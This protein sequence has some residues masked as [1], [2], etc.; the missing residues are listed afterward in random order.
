MPL[1]L[2]PD[3]KLLLHERVNL[4][5][6]VAGGGRVVSTPWS[7]HAIG[8]T[9][10]GL[11]MQDVVPTTSSAHAIARMVAESIQKSQH[12]IHIDSDPTELIRANRHGDEIS[13]QLAEAPNQ[14]FL[15][16]ADGSRL[17][18]GIKPARTLRFVSPTGNK[19]PLHV[20]LCVDANRNGV[21]FRRS[22]TL[23][24]LVGITDARFLASSEAYAGGTFAVRAIYTNSKSR[25]PVAGHKEVI[26]LVQ[27][28]RVLAQTVSPSND[29]GIVNARLWVPHDANA[30]SATLHVGTD[31]RPVTVKRSVR[32]SLVTDR[33]L[34][35][36]TDRVHARVMVHEVPSGRPA[37]GRTVTL[38]CGRIKK[39]VVTSNFGIASASFELINESVGTSKISAAVD[40][41]FATSSFRVTAYETPTFRVNV[42]PET[43]HLDKGQSG[44]VEVTVTTLSGKP[45]AGA[46]VHFEPWW[47]MRTENQNMKTDREGQT[48]TTVRREGR[49]R[50]RG[51]WVHV[52]DAD[53]RTLTREVHVRRATTAAP[54]RVRALSEL[55][56]GQPGT[57]SV[58]AK[59]RR[60]IILTIDFKKRLRVA[61][62]GDGNGLFEATPKS[63]VVFIGGAGFRPRSFPVHVADAERPGP[64]L[65][66]DRRI[67]NVGDLLTG[68]IVGPDGTVLLDVL[69]DDVIIRT[70]A[71]HIKDG[72]AKLS[73][74]LEPDL[75]GHLTIRA[76]STP[77]KRTRGSLVR[78][79]VGRGRTLSVEAKS[80]AESY[81]PGETARLDVNVRDPRGRPAPGVLGYWAIDQAVLDLSSWSDGNESRFDLARD[82]EQKTLLKLKDS[83]D[84]RS[85]V[86]RVLGGIQNLDKY[87][88][89]TY[90][91]GRV[92]TQRIEA[93]KRSVKAARA[94]M[95]ALR[96]RG[97]EAL[98]SVPL[99]RLRA[100][101]SLRETVRWLIRRRALDATA[102]IDPWGTP[103][104]VRNAWK[105]VKIYDE[106][107]GDRPRQWY[108]YT[109]ERAFPCQSAGPDRQ[110]NTMDD[111]HLAWHVYQPWGTCSKALPGSFWRLMADTKRALTEDR[112]TEID[113]GAIERA[114]GTNI[115]SLMNGTIGI[116][117]GSGG[118]F[119]G[120][121]GGR[122]LGTGGGGR[123]KYEEPVKHV[124]S[125]FLPTLCFV[126]EAIV[127]PDGK[128]E[129]KID[130]ADNITTWKTR[131]V[132]ST[133]E[134]ATGVG[135]AD[136]VVE[137][138]LHA[139]PWV[140]PR[141]TDGDELELPVA[142]RN[143]TDQP[144]NV[145]LHI[146]T[147]E[148][149]D[150]EGDSRA[151]VNVPARGTGAHRFR[152]RA[153]GHGK[154]TIKI[155][156]Q[157]KDK[158]DIAKHTVTVRR[159]AR[160]VI[161]SESTLLHAGTSWKPSI[162]LSGTEPVEITLYPSAMADVVGGFEGLIRKPSGCFE[163]T[164]S[165]L[166]PM[167]LALD[168]LRRSGQAHAGLEDR[169]RKHVA[170][171]YQRLLGFE[172]RRSPG[173]FSL[174]GHSP[175][176]TF[177][178]AYGLMEFTDMAR[179][180]EID[181]DLRPRMIK[182]LRGR[183]DK[184]GSWG[185]PA[186][187][188]HQELRSHGKHPRFNSTAYTAWA[189][190]KAGESTD[191]A[192]EWIQD[193]VDEI[194]S[195]YS[196]SL[197]ALA[198]LERNPASSTGATLV[199]RLAAMARAK[200]ESVTWES[201]SPTGL[202]ARGRV[203]R[204]ETSALAVQAILKEQHHV[205]TANP[206]IANRGLAGLIQARGADGRFGTT[207]STILALQALLAADVSF[208]K[209]G[210][211]ALS[212]RSGEREV[213][214][215]TMT[216]DTSDIIRMSFKASPGEDVSAT[217][218]GTRSIRMSA[219]QKSW[220]SWSEATRKSG[221]VSLNIKYP[222][223]VLEVARPASAQ[224]TISNVSKKTA[225]LV[226]AE[227]GIPPGCDIE[228]RRIRASN[229][230]A[231]F[232][233]RIERTEDAIVLY[234]L[235]LRPDQ[236]RQIKIPFV[237]RHRL[238]VRTTP[239]TA[240]EYY[241][242]HEAVIVPPQR[243]RAE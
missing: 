49:L 107:G 22:W 181:A 72:Q 24:Q 108:S 193:R 210:S 241:V 47:G 150:V 168:Y 73:V 219:S 146:E 77:Q 242:P 30:G 148:P 216:P 61:L 176:S 183:Q 201:E 14:A 184:D 159:D 133:V 37:R 34:Y 20:S 124:R 140:S 222:S 220:V 153:S 135:Y 142:V 141:L 215:Q 115:G 1:L 121:G 8:S 10:N 17:D 54:I 195:P 53:G 88:K 136:I 95:K 117:G 33:T 62:D 227:I 173:G 66:L 234:L 64:T 217:T 212:I 167:V 104:L 230:N 36:E 85:A 32:V 23:E 171:G 213:A 206:D 165:T 231:Q 81:R 111:I 191:R 182:F 100:T 50:D 27:A 221:R 78:V 118:A 200:K 137:Q 238:N 114:G 31:T 25:A 134:G 56:A 112:K 237:P 16:R 126:P 155:R 197:A 128:A 243:V 232:L 196:L 204:I 82:N 89:G 7:Q 60:E 44:T 84:Y 179:V 18:L 70:L 189:I 175:A 40:G 145:S 120:R 13:V 75:A 101:Y 157:S 228:T 3:R 98:A 211:C 71:A 29:A 2:L 162:A 19:H 160:E 4:D 38:R 188:A 67:A 130:L 202:G 26:K 147:S 90:S 224:V 92:R 139:T 240:Y 93:R 151:R 205:D 214:R 43:L 170:S 74:P 83:N 123:R 236:I 152:I 225:S 132:A 51:V 125:N 63:N 59:G 156:A 6:Y 41:A 42:T 11:T 163:Q 5:A 94:W 106:Q 154:S 166:Y 109:F 226:T 190:A 143:G 131:L 209:G 69:R 28:N 48:S 149:L 161:A 119:K 97:A 208:N 79:L 186:R 138:P 39:D 178:T 76:A 164:S 35:K 65:M 187:P 239:S 9:A 144:M 52:T 185:H 233:K 87:N 99:S 169:A 102:L 129:L 198:F 116:G 177:L 103:L 203:A 96:T 194:T 172:V 105:N 113:S 218:K 46:Q 80:R 15:T 180:H 223:H 86:V 174:F 127:G 192:L 122:D 207:Q 91:V 68:K 45:L 110:M 199:S 12:I 58:H 229:P 55:V 158:I 57:F 21:M 235:N